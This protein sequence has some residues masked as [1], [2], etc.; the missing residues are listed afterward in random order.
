MSKR[1]DNIRKRK[2]GRWEGRYKKGR[3]IDGKILYGS[4]Y[5]KSYR[6]VKERLSEINKQPTQT[7]LPKGREK[8]FGEVLNLWMSH[9]RIRLKGGT[10]NKYQSLIDTHIMPELGLI[11]ITELTA[12]H[13]NSF[14]DQ[15][16]TSGR[17]DGAG[18]LS[19][20]YVRSIMLV[21][22]AA[23]KYAVDEQLCLPSPA[24]G[25]GRRRKTDLREIINALRYLIRSGCSWR[26]LPQEF[27]PWQTV[28]WWFRRLMRRFL[29]ATILDI[30]TMLDRHRQKKTLAPS[31]A[32]LDSQSVKAPHASDRGIDAHKKIVGRKRHVAVDSDGRLLLVNMT[33]ANVADSTGAQ[34]ILDAMYRKWPSVKHFFA[35]G[36]YERK[37]LMDKATYLGF[38]VEV[39]K[40]TPGQ[41]G[42][43]PVAKRWVVERTFG[44]LVRWRRL[45]RD[46]ERRLD[47]SES[48]TQI[49]M[50]SIL[51]KRFIIDK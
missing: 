42:F 11:R 14:L 50:A 20:S 39:V 49:A 16:L 4:V 17:I 38:V 27:G 28:Y 6:E 33:P 25:E 21:I 18:G 29:F 13:I 43:Q 32:V 45:V 3:G 23:I 7:S 24:S 41:T 40:R 5:G 51:L 30:C 34:M 31:L 35:D 48:M 22:N 10:I 12:T 37:S 9:N 26:M 46:Y 19:P 36:A 15:K 44:W 1:G 8:T 2:D 47:V